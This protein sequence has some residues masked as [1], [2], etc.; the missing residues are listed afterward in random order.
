[1][2]ECNNYM[3]LCPHC[4]T[5]LPTRTFRRHREVFFDLNT[6]SWRRDPCLLDSSDDENNLIEIDQ[7]SP[8]FLHSPVHWDSNTESESADDLFRE[9]LLDHEIWDNVSDNEVDEDTIEKPN[10]PSVSVRQIPLPTARCS[11]V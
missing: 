7:V 11:I 8:S 3:T 6:N 1:M 4:E 5:Y 10:I 9:E 2:A